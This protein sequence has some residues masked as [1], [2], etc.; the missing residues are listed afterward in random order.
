MELIKQ[1]NGVDC[2]LAVAAMLSGESYDFAAEADPSPEKET[3]LSPADM[4]CAL[5]GLTGAPF[6]ESRRGYNKAF[7]DYGLTAYPAAILIRQS[8][9]R[10][11]H[12]I[13]TDGAQ[14]FDPEMQVSY[15]LQNYPRKDWRIIRIIESD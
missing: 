11:G 9:Q 12:W 13:A 6:R 4:I 2:G 8:D 14:I 5:E 3:G 15:S 7:S 1:R 10:F